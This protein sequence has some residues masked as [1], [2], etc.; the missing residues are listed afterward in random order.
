MVIK[1]D[2]IIQLELPQKGDKLL[3]QDLYVFQWDKGQKME[4]LN[5]PDG[6][7]VQFG[8]NNLETTLNRIKVNGFVDI[9]D[10]MLTYTEPI[11]AYVQYINFNS[12]TTRI[13][14][15]I[16]VIERPMPSEYVYPDDEQSFREQMEQIM[17]DTRGIANNALDKATNIETRANKGE[18]DGK[19]YV[20]TKE[21]YETIA[22]IAMNEIQEDI[23][24]TN[25]ELEKLLENGKIIIV[26]NNNYSYNNPLTL[27]EFCQSIKISNIYLFENVCVQIGEKQEYISGYVIPQ[28][29]S[30]NYGYHICFFL[31]EAD[32][33]AADSNRNTYKCIIEKSYYSDEVVFTKDKIVASSELSN[34]LSTE[35][36]YTKEQ[37][38]ELINAIK[39]FNVVK[40]DELPAAG[41]ELVLYL[42]PKRNED[43][44]N[45]DEYIWIGKWEHIGTTAVDLTNYVLNTRKIAGHTLKTDIDAN[46]LAGTIAQEFV[47][48]GSWYSALI[49]WLISY[50]GSK[51]QQDKNTEDILELQNK[52]KWEL[53]LDKTLPATSSDGTLINFNDLELK[54]EYKELR[55]VTVMWN[56]ALEHVQLYVNEM[57]EPIVTLKNVLGS[58]ATYSYDFT[59]SNNKVFPGRYLVMNL[60]RSQTGASASNCTESS[61]VNSSTDESVQNVQS[62]TSLKLAMT[63]GWQNSTERYI[64]VFGRK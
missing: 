46:T 19:D 3:S 62:I 49:P 63:A 41:E 28:I 29:I 33:T 57:E 20:I 7:E 34:Y 16:K 58:G 14:I 37:T 54:G 22:K 53:I 25:K 24:Q 6:T 36:A 8:N 44:D 1:K 21:D 56:T 38:N 11:N 60:K 48:G 13:K 61:F 10:I 12:E 32:K 64:R 52:D 39:Q 18:F 51:A 43:N 45:Y 4:I 59:L 42:I 2:N 30:S 5:V 55:F 27:T 35:N 47:K 9:P 26:S 17:M 40:V 15:V 23:D 31:I 50:C